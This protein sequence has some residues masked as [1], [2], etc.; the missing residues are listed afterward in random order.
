MHCGHPS[1]ST[2]NSG[3]VRTVESPWGTPG[4]SGAHRQF[5]RDGNL[6]ARASLVVLRGALSAGLPVIL[7]HRRASFLWDTPEMA[8]A[9]DRGCVNII[10]DQCQFGERTLKRTRLAAWNLGKLES[11]GRRCTG[12]RGLCSAT[13]RHHLLPGL[14]NRGSSR[15]LLHHLPV[16][17]TRALAG[18]LARA[19]DSLGVHHLTC[20]VSP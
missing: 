7:L 13:G 3:R 5:V 17:L 20:L 4:L 9:S 6:E 11:L 2:R 14:H 15:S 19:S 10:L 16:A 1:W 18:A 8:A 12:T